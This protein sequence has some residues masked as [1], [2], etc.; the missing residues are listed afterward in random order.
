MRRASDAG[1]SLVEYTLL[2]ALLIIVAVLGLRFLGQG[3]S[4][5]IDENTSTIQNAKTTI[6]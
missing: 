3:T 5:S 1:A 2:L 6:P 4:N